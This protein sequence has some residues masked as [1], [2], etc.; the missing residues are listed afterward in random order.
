[1]CQQLISVQKIN[2]LDTSP[3]ITKL[4]WNVTFI[5]ATNERTVD[6][7]KREVITKPI[8]RPKIMDKKTNNDLQ[9]VT[10]K[11]KGRT[12]GTT[13]KPGCSGRFSS[14]C[15]TSATHRAT[16]K[17]HDCWKGRLLHWTTMIKPI[18]GA[19]TLPRKWPFQ[20]IKWFV[21]YLIKPLKM[22]NMWFIM[23]LSRGL[24]QT[25]DKTWK[26]GGWRVS[27]RWCKWE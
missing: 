1:L 8:Q 5:H 2:V 13:L 21:N 25:M 12:T 17:R 19:C 11:T 24:C 9:N 10:Q 6:Y 20:A 3:R 26:R 23:D 14:F 4:L 16:V 27:G 7:W 22:G 15:S 18:Y